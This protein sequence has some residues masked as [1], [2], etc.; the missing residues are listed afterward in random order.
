MSFE[1][2]DLNSGDFLEIGKAYEEE[3]GECT[4]GCVGYAESMLVPQRDLVDFA[5]RWMEKHR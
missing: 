5:V 3:D 1:D 4:K 2:L